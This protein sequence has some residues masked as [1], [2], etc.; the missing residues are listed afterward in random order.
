MLKFKKAA[1]MFV[2]TALML[3]FAGC[4]KGKEV[5]V[6]DSFGESYPLE[7][8]TTLS[9]W[10]AINENVTA[11]VATFADTEYAK[12]AE[13]QTGV[14]IEYQHPV[15][16]QQTEQFNLLIASGELPDIIEHGWYEFPGGP[17]KAI[18]DGYIIPL[19]DYIDKYAPNFK[20]YLEENPDIDKA[21]KTD[22]GKYYVFPFI[23]GHEKLLL[24]AGPIVRTDLLSE[25][26]IESP[27]TYDDWYNMLKK[28]KEAGV[29]IP[30]SFNATNTNEIDQ[31]LGVFGAELGYYLEDNKIKFGPFA[32]E[33]KETLQM[34][35]KW[36]NE[37]LL[38]KNFTTTDSKIREANVLQGKVGATYG[39]G[40][41][42][43][44]KWIQALPADSKIKL[45]TTAY[46]VKTAGDKGAKFKSVS[47]SYTG[48]GAAITTSCENPALAVKYIDYFYSEEGSRLAN[49]GIEGKSFEMVDGVPTYMDNIKKNAEGLSMSQAMAMYM[50]SY[51]NGPFVQNVGY[52][53]QYYA[54]DE[55][56]EALVNWCKDNEYAIQFK[57]PKILC[58]S[59]EASEMAE[60]TNNVNTYRDNM[61]LKFITG[62]ESFDNYDAFI[63]QMK[64]FGVERA[65][66]IQ[67]SAYKRYQ[68]R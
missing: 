37:G 50:R 68:E 15:I 49:F 28:F 35:N 10:M 4:E 6:D 60:I 51:A 18:E 8:E 52:I 20:K 12:A 47:D 21:I 48:Y 62:I 7:T 57:I 29:E 54:L 9:Y 64:K 67:Q 58:T 25:L 24:S 36:F 14:K 41:G 66:E 27:V 13:K 1:A 63:E 17:G 61:I 2:A 65:I 44:G 56:K 3:S 31:L 55:Q 26:G 40:G 59:D 39:S 23:R 30:L 11:N 32:P 19:N 22:D 33:F 16:G 34:L 46:P 45:G 5:A 53:E 43:L 38:D 42:Q